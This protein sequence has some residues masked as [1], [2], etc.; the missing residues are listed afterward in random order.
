MLSIDLLYLSTV[1]I[2]TAVSYVKQSLCLIPFNLIVET[3]CLECSED[4]K[5]VPV[6]CL[7]DVPLL[8]QNENNIPVYLECML[9]GAAVPNY[10]K[11]GGFKQQ[12]RVLSQFWRPQV[13]NQGVGRATLPLGAVSRLFRLPVATGVPWLVAASLRALLWSSHGF[14]CCLSVSYPLLSHIRTHAIGFR[15][16][17][18]NSGWSLL[19]IVNYIRKGTFY[20]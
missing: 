4:E 10:H 7:S 3:K 6:N 5:L 19:K 9:L 2:C 13:W 16:H 15:A 17:P 8:H 12:E 11:L 14:L 1:C 18:S 20:K